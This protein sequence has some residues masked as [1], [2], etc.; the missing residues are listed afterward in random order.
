M[1]H[2]TKDAYINFHKYEAVKYL[3]SLYEK[4]VIHA[5]KASNNIFLVC[6]S[7]YYVCLI[8]EL[9][10]NYDDSNLTYKYK[11]EILE[12]HMCF[13][14]STNTTLNPNTEDL[15]WLH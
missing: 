12:N 10:I 14:A 2:L 5:D 8:K 4:H 1:T 6:K 15:H 9:E 7:Y 3:L 11:D 13:I